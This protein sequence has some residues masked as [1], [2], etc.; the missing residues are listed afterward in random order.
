M[1]GGD[2]YRADAAANPQLTPQISVQ[3]SCEVVHGCITIHLSF[4][5]LPVKFEAAVCRRS[6]T[7]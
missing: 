6:L 5:S 4:R 2:E 3:M 1:R 7:N